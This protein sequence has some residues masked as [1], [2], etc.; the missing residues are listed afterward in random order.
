MDD[1]WLIVEKLGIGL[2]ELLG[3]I[4][5]VDEVL[6]GFFVVGQIF[7]ISYVQVGEFCEVE[8]LFEL[9]MVDEWLLFCLF[10]VGLCIYVLC[11]DG[12]S[13]MLCICNGEIVIVDLDC[14]LDSGKFVVVKCYSDEKVMLKQIQY[15]EGELFFKFGNLDWLE[16]IIKIDGGW[17][18]CGVVIGKYD[19]M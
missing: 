19:L 18:I 3:E 10:G 12:E 2:Y 1:L 6:E 5:L 17:S 14:V 15:N 9:G 13:N 11:V 16:L 7:I 4:V 8:D